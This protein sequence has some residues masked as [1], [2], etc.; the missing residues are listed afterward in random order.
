MFELRFKED[1]DT[2]DTDRW[3]KSSY[4]IGDS[5]AKFEPENAYIEDG[6]LVLKMERADGTSGTDKQEDW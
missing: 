6:K 1:F 2:F 4:A 5:N 3:R